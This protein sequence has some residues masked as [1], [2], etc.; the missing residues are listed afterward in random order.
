M[1]II[2]DELSGKIAA[3]SASTVH[4]YRPYGRDEGALRW[5]LQCH[6][7]VEA[8]DTIEALSWG[9]D[10]ELLVG[11]S[12]L[13]LFATYNAS[14]EAWKKRLANPAKFAQFSYDTS[15]I[16]TTGK[17]DRLVKIWRRLSLADERFEYAYLPHPA[18][19]TGIHWRRPF[20]REQTFDNILYTLCADN[21]LRI[22]GP[23]EIHGSD[24]LRLW[25]EIDLMSSIQPRSIPPADRSGKRY[26]F[27]IDSRVF[28]TATERAVQHAS[29]D[30]Q[31]QHALAHLI[32]VAN[33]NPD[34]VVVLDDRGNMSA[35]GIDTVGC[36]H[37]QPGDIF[38]IAHVEGL[39][40]HF[41]PEAVPIEDNVQFHTFCGSKET[42]AFTLLVH[43]FD[44]RVEWHE[45]RLH[46][47]F[48]PSPQRHRLRLKAVWT[49][50]SSAV[51]KVIRTANGRAVISRTQ[52]NQSVV[53][54]QKRIDDGTTIARK[55]KLR[56]KEHIHRVWLL[57]E[58]RFVA[59][60][61]HDSISL[62]DAR[63]SRAIEVARRSYRLPGRP[64]CLLCVPEEDAGDGLVHLATITS[65]MKGTSWELRLPEEDKADLTETA[66][67][68]DFADFDLGSEKDL[69][70]VLPVDP[71]GTS[72]VISG[73]LDIFAR[74]VAISYSK[75]GVLKSWTARPDL[76]KRR[77][78]WLQTSSIDTMIDNPSLGSG[79]SIRKAA[80]VDA[81]KTLLTIWNTRAGQL[82]HEE[83]FEAEIQD[84][85]W[86]STPDNQSI[87]AVGFSNR[88]LVYTQLRYDYLD[89]RPSWAVIREM[90][91]RDWMPHPI[92][93]SVWI[94]NGS[95][96]TC[97]GNQLF[98]QDEKVQVSDALKPDLRL[99]SH[100]KVGSD[101][102]TIVSRLNGP[103]PVF[104]PQFLGQCMLSGKIRLVQR[105]L[106]ELW[107]ILKFWSEGDAFDS[108]LGFECEDFS[109]EQDLSVSFAK[110]E[111]QSSYADFADEEPETITEEVAT[112]LNE[113]LATKR[114]PF[115]SS[116]EQFHLADIVECV[117]TVEKH[118]RSLDENGV[119]FLLFFR[120]HFLHASH[121]KTDSISWREITW[122]FHSGSQ[123]ILA[124]LVSRHFQGRML[125]EHARESGIF[126]WMTDLTALVSFHV[127]PFMTTTDDCTATA[128]RNH[129]P[130]RIHKD[131][132]EE[133]R[134]LQP[135]LH[136]SQEESGSCW[137]LA[138]GH[139]VPRAICDTAST[140]E[141]L[142][143]VPLENSRS[144][145]CICSHGQA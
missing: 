123:D 139:L 133:S 108:L 71:A 3:A 93:D 82:E 59:F 53:W 55:S 109:D 39:H 86:S 112:Q 37:R 24:I 96:V 68:E 14:S 41:N 19:V 113:Q 9:L 92:G 51:K 89:A 104:H 132:R 12:N 83:R 106:L 78:E 140:L 85:D 91:T 99:A 95:F 97:A 84:L 110:K 29:N 47:L 73:F 124:D 7:S 130:E 105:I 30:E 33:R 142:Q 87:L 22:W 64:L 145:E 32:E 31:E 42:D 2:F 65:E 98:V 69:S 138:D 128:V 107:K 121:H 80:L 4:V 116:R 67:L 36:K 18:V 135:V 62:W 70:Y 38:N 61:H 118:R 63:K 88:I 49:G 43:H 129:R 66:T 21:K 134:R 11:S 115:L 103:L 23:G 120:A 46:Q 35:W 20:H 1:A 25:A 136:G 143:R 8:Q 27:Q 45:G 119:R 54:A 125:W 44:G 126:M 111:M 127:S 90:S 100:D 114:V 48:D 76:G 141:Q 6:V 79:T 77:M 101:I 72:P 74:D 10:E 50:H 94:A 16:A 102:F 5:S 81:D 56:T 26:V 34:V 40:L 131:R 117:G 122:A 52:D 144:Q 137:P 75:S 13:T 60:L 17:Y 57:Q 58:G 28:T 15:L